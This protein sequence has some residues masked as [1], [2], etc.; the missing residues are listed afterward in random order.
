MS[1]SIFQNILFFC[2]EQKKETQIECN[3]RNPTQML[4]LHVHDNRGNTNESQWLLILQHSLK[5]LLHLTDLVQ[6][7]SE[8][9]FIIGVNGGYRKRRYF[10][11]C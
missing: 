4:G 5:Y 9:I 7:E 8:D 3:I 2:V 10:E 11:E 1:V 6:V